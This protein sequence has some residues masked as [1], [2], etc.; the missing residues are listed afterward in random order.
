MVG[1]NATEEVEQNEADDVAQHL[2]ECATVLIS[3]QQ[4][5]RRANDSG[6]PAKS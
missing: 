2:P 5:D 3:N 6:P 1:L 4:A